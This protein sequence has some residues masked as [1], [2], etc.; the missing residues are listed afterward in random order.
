M[1][2]SKALIWMKTSPT[3]GD[4]V[5]GALKLEAEQLAAE[6]E[7]QGLAVTILR[8]CLTYG[9]GVR[10]NMQN[11]MRAVRRGLYVHVRSADTVR[12]LASVDT[13]TAAIVHLLGSPEGAGTFNVA[14]RRAHPTGN[15]GS[16]TSR[17]AL[18][19]AALLPSLAGC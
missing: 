12:S 6:A 3:A 15:A 19:H 2:A 18:A 14:R 1:P 8:P 16:T 17:A 7:A 5:Y 10:F 9:P 13:V 4:T 11:L